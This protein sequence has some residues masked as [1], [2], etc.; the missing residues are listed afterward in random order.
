METSDVQEISASN[1]A[2]KRSSES[3]IAVC[4]TVHPFVHISLLANVYCNEPLV[5]FK[6]SGF[7]FLFV[8]LF[9][10]ILFYGRGG[11]KSGRWIQRDGEMSGI[12]VHDVK[13]MKNPYNGFF[14]K[15]LTN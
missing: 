4:H 11:C 14:K 6:A 7:R 8:C 3:Y 12:G 2:K 1:F 5:C 13:F 15:Y 9:Y 10:F